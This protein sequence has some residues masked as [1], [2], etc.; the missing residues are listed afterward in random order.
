MAKE[1]GLPLRCACWKADTQDGSREGRN[2]YERHHIPRS[3][4]PENKELPLTMPTERITP[5]PLF[6]RRNHMPYP[7]VELH[8]WHLSV[9]G[10]I[11]SPLR[12]NYSDLLRLPK[13]T[14][15]VTLEC[16]GNKRALWDPKTQG[17]QFALGAISNAIWTGVPLN[18]V[19]D[20]ADVKPEAM[21]IVF[22]GM[23][24]GFRTDMP[25]VLSYSRSLPL[26]KAMHP[27]TLL[28]LY[29]NFE[30]LSVEHGCPVRLIVPGWY[31]MASVK[32]LRRI[33]VMDHPFDGPFQTR[34]Y[35]LLTEPHDYVNAVPVTEI[36]VNSSISY[37]LDQQVIRRGRHYVYGIAWSGSTRVESIS[38]STDGGYHWRPAICLD[39][40]QQYSWRRWVFQW[41]VQHPGEYTIMSRAT[42]ELGATQPLRALW[43]VKGYMNNSIHTVKVYIE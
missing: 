32:W 40:K 18:T 4:F 9:E 2:L 25:D 29:M 11:K 21:E 10:C 30:P 15:P 28:A 31:A 1:T 12:L 24:V 6:Y 26:T 38:V 3:F 39:S 20:V 5:V 27:D 22:E 42:D 19:L 13:I 8:K 43:N 35:V 7:I 16:A 41:N 23:D 17:E 36:Q 14:L 33:V 34:D 37:P